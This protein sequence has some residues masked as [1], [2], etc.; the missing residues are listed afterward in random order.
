MVDAEADE[1]QVVAAEDNT[2][3]DFYDFLWGEDRG[4]WNLGS[5]AY[6][7]SDEEIVQQFADAVETLGLQPMD[8]AL[9]LG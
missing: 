5:D 2:A 7:A 8:D 4:D 3:G 1:L 6:A 9:L